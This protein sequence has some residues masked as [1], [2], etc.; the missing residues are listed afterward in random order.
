MKLFFLQSNQLKHLTLCVKPS[1]MEGSIQ[2]F[3]VRTPAPRPRRAAPARPRAR[4]K[5]SSREPGAPPADFFFFLLA[6]AAL[7]RSFFSRWSVPYPRKPEA[8]LRITL[9]ATRFG[10]EER[11][12]TCRRGCRPR[13]HPPPRAPP[14]STCFFFCGSLFFPWFFSLFMV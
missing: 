14:R 7:A 13:S 2:A 12:G 1:I 6:E 10:P 11:G 3:T 5:V 9:T 4:W 8:A